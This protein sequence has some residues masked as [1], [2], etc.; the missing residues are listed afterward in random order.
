MFSVGSIVDTHYIFFKSLR[1]TERV[2]LLVRCESIDKIE[3]ICMRIMR[4]VQ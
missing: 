3:D 2:C 1:Y 4:Q